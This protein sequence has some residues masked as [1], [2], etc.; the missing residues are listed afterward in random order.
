M[1]EQKSVYPGSLIASDDEL[2]NQ[3]SIIESRLRAVD[4]ILSNIQDPG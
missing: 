4:R 3:V 2:R 1:D